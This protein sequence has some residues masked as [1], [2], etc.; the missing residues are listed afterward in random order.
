MQRK[1][2]EQIIKDL[3]KKMVFLVGPR[4][5]GKTWLSKEI[6]KKFSHVAY[7][8]YDRAEDREIIRKEI[9]PRN[10][11]LLI[12]DELH[13]MKDWKNYLKGVFDTKKDYLKIL[14]TGSARLNTFRQT[15]DSLAGRFFIHRLLPFSL[16][17]L[18][19]VKEIDQNDIEKLIE[20]GGFPEPYLADNSEEADR[21]RSQYID[22]LIRTDI[23]DFET[24]H[25]FRAVQMTLDLLR[26]RVGSPIS[27]AS[28]AEDV[29]VSPATVKKY[30][31]IFESLFIVF[32]ITPYSRNI[33]RS[34]LKEPKIYFFDN[35]LVEGDNGARFENFAAVSFLKHLWA[36]S[37]VTGKNCELKYL[38]TK[39]GKEVDFA[40][41][42]NGEVVELVETKYRDGDLSPALRYFA[43]K[44]QIKGTQ[45]VKELKREKSFSR[46]DIVAAESY[47]KNL[48]L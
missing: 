8:N 31:D 34:I 45:V 36:K 27:L 1:Q 43:N 48:F 23:L 17:E 16:A 46:I 9:W 28:I 35:G 37:D 30:I 47:F 26:R 7:L 11:E 41:V 44:Y 22:G 40:L 25:N 18:K 13:K 20:R 4:Q 12:L 32:R 38:R 15:G 10:T 39:E 6:G 21:W 3:N 24:I 14:V 42:E 19:S 33:A 5:V 2:T 29:Q